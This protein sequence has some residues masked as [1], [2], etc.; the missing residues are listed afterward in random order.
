MV[1]IGYVYVENKT[2]S[3][4]DR[5]NTQV[6]YQVA[7]AQ[8]E[9]TLMFYLTI[10]NKKTTSLSFLAGRTVHVQYSPLMSY[11]VIGN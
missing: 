3:K 11:H 2:V 1:R 7:L 8:V 5:I 10:V 9:C 4:Q 6:I